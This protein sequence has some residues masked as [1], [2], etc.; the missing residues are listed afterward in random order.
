MFKWISVLLSTVALAIAALICSLL[1]APQG[2][3]AAYSCSGKHIY[4]PQNLTLIAEN[5]PAGT[6]FCIHDG[7]YN[8]SSP[9]RAQ[10]ND[11]Y[12]GLYNDST[13]PEVVTSQAKQLFNVRGS[14]GVEIKGLKIAGAVGGNYCE[15]GCG[16]GIRGGDNLTVRN[17]WITNNM[18]N[19]IGG[20]GPRLLVED[21]IINYNGS[22]SFSILDGGLSTTSGIKSS[23]GS[24]TVVRSE[25]T[26]NYWNGVW[27]DNDCNA[28]TVKNST[29]SRNGKAG[30]QNE[31]SS[32]PAVITGN[33]IMGNSQLVAANRHAGL[34]IV[35]S[36]RV[37]VYNNTFGDNVG[38]GVK[39]ID[40]GRS[41]G[42]SDVKF[43]NNIMNLDA[44]EGCH[45]SGV[46]CYG[47]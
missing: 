27:C 25:V 7:T 31:I 43:H 4:P 5:S 32:G 42:L 29:L 1:Y 18:N 28:L 47:N 33:N 19:G 3:M 46:S 16:Q 17:A 23:E 30:I 26:Y 39:F 40:D 14:S 20:V 12:I 41:P 38:P 2:A 6:I 36:S 11:K 13:R 22:Y 9:V 10:N 15:P 44:L 35:S 8:V 21:S 45:L 24:L 37:D 34:L